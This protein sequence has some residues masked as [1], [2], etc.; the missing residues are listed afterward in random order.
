MIFTRITILSFAY[1]VALFYDW[2]YPDLT[3]E[4]RTTIRQALAGMAIAGLLKAI[5]SYGA[6]YWPN[7]FA[8]L[9]SALGMAALALQGEE[10]QAAIWLD[11]A[12][13]WSKEF[14]DT[15]G[16]VGMPSMGGHRLRFPW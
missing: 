11:Q 1:L 7:G 5:P 12:M 4:E 16:R 2:C 3:Q 15:R 9:T 13:A 8:V 10:P 14:F 6:V